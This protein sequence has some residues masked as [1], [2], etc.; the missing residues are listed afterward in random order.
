MD[1]ETRH[2]LECIQAN[3]IFPRKQLIRED[4]NL[5]VPFLELHGESTE[6]VGRAEDAIIALSNYRLHIKF[7]ES[8]V[9]VPLQLIESVECRDIFQLHLTCKDC[10]VIRCQFSTFEQCQDWLKRLN[11]AIRPPAKIEDLFSFAYHAWCME[12]YASEKEQHGDLCRPASCSSLQLA[13]W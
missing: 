13:S 12:V 10:K 8:L 11:N 5:Q 4:E 7:K 6:Y 1:E 3:Q 9:N 2:S